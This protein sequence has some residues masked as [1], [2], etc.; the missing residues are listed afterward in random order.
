[1]HGLTPLHW[2]SGHGRVDLAKVLVA[3]G[4]DIDAQRNNG[5]TPLHEA[6][7]YKKP[8]LVTYLVLQGADVNLTNNE[9]KKPGEMTDDDAVRIAFQTAAAPLAKRIC[10]IS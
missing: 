6:A 9:G 2:A 4:A 3:A 7:N 1:M 8:D 5:N 10:Q